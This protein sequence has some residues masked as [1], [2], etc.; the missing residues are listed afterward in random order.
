MSAGAAGHRTY[1]RWRGLADY[2]RAK[3]DLRSP[4]ARGY[5]DQIVVNDAD[6]IIIRGRHRPNWCDS[7]SDFAA[8]TRQHLLL[9]ISVQSPREIGELWLG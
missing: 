6:A 2:S 8:N 5:R 7:C 4:D 1:G 3:G 9:A